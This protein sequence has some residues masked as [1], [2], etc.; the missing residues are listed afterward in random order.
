MPR[1]ATLPTTIEIRIRQNLRNLPSRRPNPSTAPPS[2]TSI[3][4]GQDL[5]ICGRALPQNFVLSSRL[6]EPDRKPIRF[7]WRDC[8]ANY[9]PISP[10][11]AP[12]SVLV[13]I[14][15]KVRSKTI[16]PNFP[17]FRWLQLRGRVSKPPCV[18]SV[19]CWFV[20][21]T[22]LYFLHTEWH[23]FSCHHICDQ[24]TTFNF[25]SRPM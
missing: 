5:K 14:W 17:D 10:R 19:I 20:D 22:S 2:A 25:L 15:R 7:A 11:H 1:D 6:C 12:S 16:S 13:R 23:V 4:Y 9:C 24:A 18:G 8:A 3:Y 21:K